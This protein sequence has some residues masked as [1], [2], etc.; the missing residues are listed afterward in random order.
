MNGKNTE[1]NAQT[2]DG[3]N[4]TKDRGSKARKGLPNQVLRGEITHLSHHEQERYLNV[5]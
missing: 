2:F 1:T 5:I 3:R 4:A